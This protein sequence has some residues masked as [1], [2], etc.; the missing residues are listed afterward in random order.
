[1]PIK[2]L[3]DIKVYT[4][5]VDAVAE[6][7]STYQV[8][9]DSP[10]EAKELAISRCDEDGFYADWNVSSFVGWAPLD[11][12]LSG[13]DSFQL[14]TSEGLIVSEGVL[15]LVDDDKFGE[16]YTGREVHSFLDRLRDTLNGMLTIGS[17]WYQKMLEAQGQLRL[18]TE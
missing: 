2:D 9:S 10:E 18:P 11:I 7:S 15:D 13:T 17:P 3:R 8:V 12:V 5:Y 1:M 14:P 4:V 16:F 6:F